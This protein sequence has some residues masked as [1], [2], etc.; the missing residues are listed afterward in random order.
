MATS[1]PSPE[2]LEVLRVRVGLP[3]D[4]TSKDDEITA[5]YI[6]ALSWMEAYLDRYLEPG[7][8]TESFTHVAANVLSLK[9]YPVEAI[10]SM[11]SDNYDA[12]PVAYHV[13][14][15][16]GLIHFDGYAVAH[17][18]AV[19]YDAK[20]ALTGALYMAFLSLF[21]SVW[22]QFH[23]STSTDPVG[24]GAIKAISSDGARVEFDVSGSSSSSSGIDPSSGL[25][26]GVAAMLHLYRRESV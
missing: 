22:A 12:P 25:P 10:V 9:G 2:L 6:A 20:P 26:F 21:D 3:A 13:E 4:D 17:E 24:T 1:A 11:S 23:A 8:Y 15:V 19:T 16:N 14:E 5:T 7:T 18:I